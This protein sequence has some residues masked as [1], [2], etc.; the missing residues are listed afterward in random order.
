MTEEIKELAELRELANNHCNSEIANFLK[1]SIV[2][3]VKN[4]Q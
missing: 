2:L 4:E 1:V 3:K